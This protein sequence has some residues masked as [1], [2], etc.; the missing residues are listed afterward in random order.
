MSKGG[1]QKVR[2]RAGRAAASTPAPALS[3]VIPC[4]N[5]AERIGATVHAVAEHLEAADI[6]FELVLVNDGSLDGTGAVLQELAAAD[7]RVRAASLPQNRGKG[8]AVRRGF[9]LARGAHVVFYDADLSF[10][11]RHLVE[12]HRLLDEHDVVV[13]QRGTAAGEYENQPPLRGAAS[14]AFRWLTSTLVGV[15][16]ADTQCGIKAFRRPVARALAHV[17]KV[18]GFGFDVELLLLARR[19]GLSVLP[20]PVDV[21]H[22]DGSTV[23]M[24]RDGP[25]VAHDLLRLRVRVA[26]GD[27]PAR[28]PEVPA[29]GEAT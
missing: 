1:A 24:L 27:Y 16:V 4:Y 10:P 5:E 23:Q 19:W 17:Q 29:R 22:R 28:M 20:V 15:G 26:R 25:L 18:D 12:F 2:S 6:D 8:A 14:A 21:I 11:V 13:G 9:A 7:P 3:V